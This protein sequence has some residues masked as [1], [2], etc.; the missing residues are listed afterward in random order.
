MRSRKLSKVSDKKILRFQ[1]TIRAFYRSHKRS[2]PWRETNDPYKIFVSEIMLQQTQTE[3][4][5]PKYLAFT[6]RFPTWSSLAQAPLKD[7]LT[8][9]SG[10]GYNRRARFLHLAAQKVVTHFNRELPS[11]YT[12]L[13]SLPG[14]GE[15]TAHALLA[16]A[17]N[18]RALCIETNIRSAI[19]YS[20]FKDD[21]T[22]HDRNVRSLLEQTLP[23]KNFRSWYYALMDYGVHVKK[24]IP[25][26][27]KRSA[28]YARQSPFQGSDR[29]VRGAILKTLAARKKLSVPQLQKSFQRSRHEIDAILTSLIRDNL[30]VRKGRAFS[31]P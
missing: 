8:L 16:F 15:Y 18:R 30:I 5:V 11:D 4:V 3:R 27:N 10:L 22:V 14:V 13:R 21:N 7:V 23:T 28:H 24:T 2:F 31:L 12:N 25:R 20:F 6:E 17:F 19:I 29:Q 26:I 9:W 1:K